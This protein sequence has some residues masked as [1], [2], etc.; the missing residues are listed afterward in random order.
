MSHLAP[1]QTKKSTNQPWKFRKLSERFT[2]VSIHIATPLLA[3]AIV[4]YSPIRGKSGFAFTWLLLHLITS[5]LAGR[6]GIR[7]KSAANAVLEVFMSASVIIFLV[8]AGSVLEPVFRRGLQGFHLN[9]LTQDATMAESGAELTIGGFG[10][11]ILGS[12]IVVGIAGL[13]AI[14]LGILAALYVTEVRGRLTPYVRFFVQAMS[15]VPSIVAGLF[16]YASFIVTGILQFS[17]FAG[18]LALV[19]LMLPTVARTAEEVLKLVPEDLR[20]SALAL[21]ATQWKVVFKIV[22]PFARSGLITAGILGIARV[23][24]ETAP[25]LLTAFGNPTFNRDPFNDSISA[26]PIYVF[27]QM[28]L[29]AENDVNRAWSACLVLLTIIAVLFAI[30]RFAAS[31][32]R[33]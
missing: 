11:A 14:P 32:L 10:H 16:I 9:L 19:I 30:A 21:G 3:A 8:A 6:F 23:A 17:G 13:I 29:G 1:V 28:L 4:M 18:S 5:V 24:G 26:L 22:L 25:L 31:K 27:N 15:G 7:R 12:L 2:I 20:T 33:H